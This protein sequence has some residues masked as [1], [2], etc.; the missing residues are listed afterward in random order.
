MT[1]TTFRRP[2][3]WK[4]CART[5]VGVVREVNEDAIFENPEIGLWAVA[6]TPASVHLPFSSETVPFSR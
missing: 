5:D 3:V 2:I 4:S 6:G 1:D